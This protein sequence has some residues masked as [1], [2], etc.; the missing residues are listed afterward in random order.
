MLDRGEVKSMAELAKPSSL[1]T[2]R[3]SEIAALVSASS[4][5]TKKIEQLT[6]SLMESVMPL[7]AQVRSK[8]RKIRTLWATANPD[9]KAILAEQSEMYALKKKIS[10]FS[11]SFASCS[12]HSLPARAGAASPAPPA[13][14]SCR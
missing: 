1:Q 11:I 5:Q 2:N 13:C 7:V 10:A 6:E 4:E 3:G 8:H 9:R 14:S 12:N